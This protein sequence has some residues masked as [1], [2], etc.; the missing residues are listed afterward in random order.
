MYR[1]VL[2]LL[3]LTPVPS[4]AADLGTAVRAKD[5]MAAETI[6]GAA[7]DPV[8][9]RL[10]RYM[11]AM[12]PGASS[13]G[14][15]LAVMAEDADW[16]QG[17]LLR[18]YGEAVLNE[19]DD[20]VAA[21]ACQ[22]RVPGMVPALLRCAGLIPHGEALA[23][24]AWTIGVTDAAAEAAFMKRW[25]AVLGLAVQAERFERLA[26]NESAVPGGALAR[27]AV[28]IEPGL[29]PAAEARL[30]L[31]RDDAAG[32][33]LFAALP[34]LSQA[35]PGLV[36]E[37]ARWYRRA[38]RDEEAARV[39]IERGVAASAA[40]AV[41]RQGAFWNERNTLIRRLLR[42][43]QDKLA[44]EVAALP[45]A[46]NGDAAFLAGWIA[47]RRL[48]QPD[49]AAAHFR[50][51]AGMSGAAITQ[52]RAEYWLGRALAMAGQAAEAQEAYGK[53]AGWTTTYYGQ[54]GALA[55]GDGMAGLMQRMRTVSDPAWDEE[56]ALTFAGT[57]MARA[58]TIAVA[59][60]QK[61]AAKGF[62]MA[63]EAQESDAAGRSI[64]ARFA[65]AL[66]MPDQAVA[67]AR[68]AGR[69]GTMVP[70]AGWPDGVQIPMGRVE[71]AV[72][73]GVIRQES[74]FD[75]EARSPAGA[76][77]LMQLMPATAA[78]VARVSGG[79][80]G[81]LTDAA[82]NVRLGTA[83]LGAQLDRFRALPPALAAYNAGPTRA[84]D[85]LAGIGDP[86]VGAIDPIDWVELIP[87]DETRN[88]VQR[89]V[90][91]VMIYRAR[92][93]VVL[94]HPVLGWTMGNGI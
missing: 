16:P 17:V 30:A 26:W 85:W 92:E 82:V 15:I 12:S 90:E 70:E 39:W 66:G 9:G 54:L 3:L 75:A 31:K 44:Y 64:V 52:G 7:A 62:L 41:E 80:V 57:E 13:V 69:D 18:R 24:R 86:A 48:D 78:E 81:E 49:V 8:S 11:R 83:Y 23:R 19:R 28:R 21:E 27:Q 89:I 2:L 50:M 40:V 22:R 47:L 93:G 67:V 53:A 34:A 14:E 58:A 71:R 6:A 61:A 63:L 94:P 37:L 77:G 51:L 42:T 5:W 32:P 29:R 33:A 76:M 79:A 84:R 91:N 72:A 38:N 60:G 43:R 68:S 56:R 74:S 88:Y 87:F 73:L 36:L 55:L 59:W 20:R 25:G 65:A 46:K 4:W 35:D 45:T 1:A 10:V